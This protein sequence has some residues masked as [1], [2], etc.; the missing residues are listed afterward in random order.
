MKISDTSLAMSGVDIG[1][2]GLTWDVNPTA[3]QTVT[4]KYKLSSSGVWIVST[5]ALQILPNGNISGT[6]PYVITGVAVGVTYDVQIINNCGGVGFSKQITT[7]SLTAYT[8]NYL[9]E[10]M[11]Y[12]ICGATPITL[13]T[14]QPFG[15]GITLYSDIGLT[16]PVTGYLYV[17]LNGYNI[18]NLNTSTGKVGSDTGSACT[19]GTGGLYRVDNSTA[20]I[21]AVP[22]DTY[23]TNGAF[24]VGGTLYLDEALT[25]PVTGYSYVTVVSITPALKKIYALNSATGAIGADTGL[26]CS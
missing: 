23:Y 2:Y 3:T 24:V 11:L 17:T 26:L 7:P 4:V 22:Q 13:Y 19:T 5:N 8:N 12:L 20:T 25:T 14:S 21:C 10:N 15:A 6:T 18:F 1:I 16:T 9:L